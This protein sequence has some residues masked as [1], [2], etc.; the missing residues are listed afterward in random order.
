M[1][2]TLITALL[3]GLMALVLAGLIT[4]ILREQKRHKQALASQSLM[5][6]HQLNAQATMIL[7]MQNG[8]VI[9]VEKPKPAPA[10]IL[11]SSWYTR[12]RTLLSLSFL[13]ML[14]LALFVQSGLAAGTLQELDRTATLLG[15]P[16]VLG[17]SAINP[18]AHPDSFSTSPQLTASQRIVRVNSA[19]RN[20]YY[21]TYQWLV[22][23]FSSC[24][25][26]ALEE[27]MN[28]YGRHYIA[29]DVLQVELNM[30]V[31]NVSQGLI[32]GEASMARV[33]NY[34]GFKASPNPPRTLQSLIATAN[35]GYP[36]IV[37]SPV[38]IFVV[39][40]GDSSHIYVVDSAPADLT[41]LTYSQFLALWD[42]FSVLVTPQ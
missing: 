20:Q 3:L 30:G 25:G 17:V 40:G 12:R 24:S 42:G 8:V 2:S 16:Q 10:L 34:F 14:F 28:A 33:A 39:R 35:K 4:G 1:S 27:V 29:A 13:L 21:T 7:R 41:V 15:V 9:G 37:G 36:V 19:D 22:W 31:W 18:A 23:S 26:I 32:G 11:P 5:P 38:H 6:A